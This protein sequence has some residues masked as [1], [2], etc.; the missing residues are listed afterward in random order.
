MK[1]LDALNHDDL[2]RQLTSTRHFWQP[3]LERDLGGVDAGQILQNLTGFFSVLAEWSRAEE[4]ADAA[5]V[6]APA[7]PYQGEVRHD[8]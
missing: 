3:R 5:G 4:I 7:T 2:G 1:R 8:R 6:T